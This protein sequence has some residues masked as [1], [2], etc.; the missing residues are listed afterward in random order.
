[1]AWVRGDR[2]A[3]LTQRLEFG[4]LAVDGV[5]DTIS[6]RRGDIEWTTHAAR[7]SITHNLFCYGDYHAPMRQALIAWLKH[8]G[9]MGDEKRH[10]IEIGANI[11]APTLL[12]ARETGLSVL[13]IEPLP[14]NFELLERNV[15]RNGLSEQVKCLRAAV[16][17]ERGTLSMVR[18]PKSGRSEVHEGGNA[19]GFGELTEGCRVVD[20]VRCLPLDEAVAEQNIEPSEVAFVWSDVQGFEGHVIA[21]GGSLWS[22]GVPL[23]AELWI[24]GLEAHGGFDKF[25]ESVHEHFE[26]FLLTEQLMTQGTQGKPRPIE[27]LGPAMRAVRGHTDGLLIPRSAP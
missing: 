1:M 23:F 10:L 2:E 17:S 7:E 12:L 26:G 14:D 5:A 21:S 18:H 15:S 9:Y 4:L 27:E 8:H 20:S 6:F 13:A 25:L 22:A 16:S 19:Q 24:P 3:L 11:G